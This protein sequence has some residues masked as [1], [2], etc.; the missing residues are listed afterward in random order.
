MM[1]DEHS[2]HDDPFCEIA[3]MKCYKAG[4]RWKPDMECLVCVLGE[5]RSEV[6]GVVE[7]LGEGRAE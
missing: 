5:I 2:K 1:P 7:V 6:A 3:D 4:A